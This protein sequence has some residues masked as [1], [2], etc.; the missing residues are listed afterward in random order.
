MLNEPIEVMRPAVVDGVTAVPASPPVRHILVLFDQLKNLDGGAE[1]SLLKLA[2]LLPADR[3]RLSIATF[4]EPVDRAF[5][6]EFKCPVHVLPFSSTLSR[7]SLRVARQLRHIIRS[8]KV[9][10]VQTFFETADLWGGMVA[11]LSG[12]PIIISSRRDMG[13]NQQRKHR[14]A[15]RILRPMFDRVHTV[16]DAVR[17]FTLRE[18]LGPQDRV[19]TIHNGINLGQAPGASEKRD[20]RK[21]YGLGANAPIIVDVAM[22]KPVKGFE[23]LVRAAAQVC[24]HRPDAMFVIVGGV[25]D[26]EYLKGVKALISELGLESNFLFPGLQNDPSPYFRMADVFC[27]LSTT[28][29]LSNALLEAMAAGLPCI[30][31]RVGG[32]PEVVEDGRT[33]YIVES[34]DYDAAAT[35]ILHLLEFPDQARRMGDLSRQ[36]VEKS[37]SAQRMVESFVALYDSCLEEK[38]LHSS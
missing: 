27:H 13:F 36:R 19:V 4:L 38:V 10:I 21:S 30:I 29:G 26:V 20:L 5:L 32:N 2:Q 16:S 6:A 28:D 35:R 23:F 1:R 33:G 25:V 37:H 17:D 34:A 12:C 18:K 8:Q 14:L 9:S 31:S 7:E 22:V 11:K 3:Y 24:R 15:Y